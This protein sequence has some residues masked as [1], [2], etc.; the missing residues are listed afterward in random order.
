MISTDKCNKLHVLVEL[1][2]ESLIAREEAEVM[3]SSVKLLFFVCVWLGCITSLSVKW[4]LTCSQSGVQEVV[5]VILFSG[6]SGAAYGRC[7]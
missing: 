7:P 3:Y 4:L 1:Q 5:C 6:S 2:Q